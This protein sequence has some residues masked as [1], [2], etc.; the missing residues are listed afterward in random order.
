MPTPGSHFPRATAG[1]LFVKSKPRAVDQ[2][3]P[4]PLFLTLGSIA[5]IVAGTVIWWSNRAPP[6]M[7]YDGEVF[8]TVDAL[9]TAITSRNADRLAACNERLDRYQAEGRLTGA[10]AT[11]L[12]DIVRQAERGEWDA[13]GRRLY[14]LIL[15]QRRE[16]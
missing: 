1:R 5:V 3:S 12:D 14:A 4:W 15:G 8:N 6:Q 11:A 9:F 16:T 10:A 13:A 7:K 2:G